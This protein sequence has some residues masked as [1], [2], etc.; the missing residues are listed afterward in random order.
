MRHTQFNRWSLW[1]ALVGS[2][3]VIGED[4]VAPGSKPERVA[5]IGTRHSEGTTPRHSGSSELA[6]SIR[7][8]GTFRA[9]AGR[10]PLRF[11]GSEFNVRL[12]RH[13]STRSVVPPW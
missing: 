11:C 7:G 6:R 2:M 5:G 10:A 3:L 8:P 9:R 4:Q 12:L 13:D 1:A